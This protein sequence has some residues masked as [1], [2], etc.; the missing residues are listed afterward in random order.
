MTECITSCGALL[1]TR[2]RIPSLF[3]P[4]TCTLIALILAAGSGTPAAHAQAPA[5]AN[6]PIL[7]L[8]EALDL[9]AS[10]SPNIDAADAQ[11]RAATAA[12]RVAALRPNPSLN[13]DFENV[14]GSRAYNDIEPPKQLVSVGLPFELGGKRSARIALADA[15]GDRAQIE[16][17]ATGAEVRLAITR[18][19]VQAV[20]ADRRLGTARDQAAI[21]AEAVHAARIRVLAGRASP[22]EEQRAQV[23]RI[24]ADAAADRAIRLAELARVNLGRRIGRPVTGTLD[25]PWFDRM[26]NFG[27]AQR[28]ADST[29]AVATAK[30]DEQAAEAQLH[31]A[32]SQRLPDVTLTAGVR[33]LPRNNEMAAVFGVSVPLPIF[34][35]GTSL[36]A[37][38][39]AER[40]RAAALRRAAE[41]DN[42]QAVG[43]AQADLANAE[44]A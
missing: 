40:D 25:Q 3:K 36:I 8:A 18:A 14:G 12:R 20:A 4:L 44:L 37:L 2:S 7:T 34:N 35:S 23:L 32:R 31:L 28:D 24:S 6:A 30:S 38:A 26:D 22:L 41:F 1:R 39:S 5:P 27:P 16:R 19:Y 43:Q 33:R 29:L 11:L 15:H 9:A 21:A 42:E 10:T 17:I 13:A